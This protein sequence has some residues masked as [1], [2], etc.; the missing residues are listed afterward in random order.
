VT[1][2]H[3]KFEEDGLDISLLKD[4]NKTLSTIINHFETQ[5][6]IMGDRPHIN[7][8][9]FELKACLI[10]QSKWGPSLVIRSM[11]SI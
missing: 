1:R 3:F 5:N 9:K 11:S 8:V 2:L 6:C 10:F 4:L 7:H